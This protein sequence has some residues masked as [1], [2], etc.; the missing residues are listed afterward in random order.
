MDFEWN[1]DRILNLHVWPIINGLL[2]DFTQGEKSYWSKRY[3]DPE[4]FSIPKPSSNYQALNKMNMTEF[5]QQTKP[6]YFLIV[7]FHSLTVAR[8]K[9]WIET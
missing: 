1:Q 2:N 4:Y 3:A 5:H 6:R 9:A 7:F 8:L